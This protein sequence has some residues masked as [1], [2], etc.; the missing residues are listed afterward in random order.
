[1]LRDANTPI[2]GPAKKACCLR[3]VEYSTNGPIRQ[4]QNITEENIT[5][6]EITRINKLVEE[7]NCLPAC[8]SLAYDVS[9]IKCDVFK[10]SDKTTLR[11]QEWI[12]FQLEKKY[13][14]F[15]EKLI[16]LFS[17]QVSKLNIFFKENEFITLT[18][19]EIYGPIDF[20]ANCGGL[21]GLFTGASFL[22][23]VE[24]LYYCS[25]RLYCNRLRRRNGKE[26]NKMSTVSTIIMVE[27]ADNSQAF[28]LK[29]DE[30]TRKEVDHYRKSCD[31]VLDYLD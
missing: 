17:D 29:H 8:T 15:N 30:T 20:I 9:I 26:E 13:F 23:I 14:P 22:S 6:E 19:S 18:R 31:S 4:V 27:E 7:C 11:K 5:E 3:A 12:N 16:V 24:L 10:E 21:I 1:M 28:K 2:C 25:L